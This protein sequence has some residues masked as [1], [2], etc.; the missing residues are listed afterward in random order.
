MKNTKFNIIAILLITAF[1]IA[2]SPITMQNDTYYTI[3]IGEHILQN[4]IDMQDA[5][6]WHEGLIYT[7]PH[8]GY[9]VLIYLIYAIGNLIGGLQGAYTAIYISTCILSS[10]LGIALFKV[11]KKIAKN[12]VIS[13]FITIATM[14][15]L[16]GYIAA[17]AQLVTFILFV[18][19]IYFI[20]Q[21]LENKKLTNILGLIVIPIL[22][23]NLHIAVW[24]FYFILYL[25]YIAE[26]IISLILKCKPNDKKSSFKLE[27][28]RRENVKYLIIVMIVCLLT[29]FITPLGTTTYTYL[30]NTMQGNTTQNINEHLPMTL[31]QHIPV[32]VELAVLFA[33]LIF[34]KN[35]I[36]LR[37]L[38]MIVGLM[39]LMFYSRRQLTMFVLIVG[40]ILN[41]LI[42]QTL[43]NIR[44]DA[45]KILD[46]VLSS[47][48]ALIIIAVI[49]LALSFNFVNE[50]KED[51]YVD[52]TQ[53]P[54][55]AC[56]WLLDN[57]EVS[58][59]RIFNEYNYGSYMLYRG[60]PVFIDSRAD[61][62]TP[63]FNKD[64]DIFTDFINT[65]SLNVYYE[66]I[67]EKYDITHIIL[68]SNSKVNM[69]I[70][71]TNDGKY[72]Q[73][74]EDNYFIIYEREQ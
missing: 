26:Y 63:E 15:L 11:N 20:E 25:P 7:Y 36:K 73:I 21:F 4:G 55:K 33:I 42:I 31:V 69:I 61:L 66:T 38:F 54:T 47:N 23:A 59:I 51:T 70:Q 14:Y 40:I 48:L 5:F 12:N 44:E 43:K 52:E 57:L 74:Y 2:V 35:K 18:L 22:I 67:F 6:S 16:K 32:I 9:D 37:D 49:L 60:I 30:I 46:K 65:S 17:R 29:G 1:C 72:K 3:A 8:W 53:Y 19:E 68:Y 56:S 71:N 50:K 28:E 45:D 64:V 10:I 13:L 58:N 62:Y 24:Y 41:K 27:I 34:F 39:I